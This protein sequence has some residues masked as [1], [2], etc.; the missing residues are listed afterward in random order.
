V[1]DNPDMILDPVKP[2]LGGGLPIL[3]G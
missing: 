1:A 2:D 3:K